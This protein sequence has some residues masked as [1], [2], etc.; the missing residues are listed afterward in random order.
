MSGPWIAAF[1]ALTIV[2]LILA[3]VVIG[4]M[5]RTITTM[6]SIEFSLAPVHS[7]FGPQVGSLAPPM[8]PT[9]G[10]GEPLESA[11]AWSLTVFLEIGCDPCRVLALDIQRHDWD[12]GVRNILISDD[13][14][15]VQPHK[16]PGWT[17][18]IDS[19]GETSHAWGVTG[20]PA[21]F[22]TDPAGRI[23]SAT[24]PNTSSDLR[25]ILR[26]VSEAKLS[27]GEENPTPATQERMGVHA[28]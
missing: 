18:Q 20:T 1:L 21:A 10:V 13:P 28:N 8:P 26:L 4:L 5:H 19:S 15:L 27:G 16:L 6:R 12:G 22:L 2:V 7:N 9:P 14:Q 17:V 3:I 24:H 23:R 11:P 25:R